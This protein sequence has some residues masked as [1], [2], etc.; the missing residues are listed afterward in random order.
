MARTP[1]RNVVAVE[2]A[3][4]EAFPLQ[5][6]VYSDDDH[7]TAYSLSSSSIVLTWK[8]KNKKSDTAVITKTSANI[9]QIEKTDPT[10]GVF[11][12]KLA[13]TDTVDLPVGSYKFDALLS[14]SSTT[15][16]TKKIIAT[17]EIVVYESSS[18]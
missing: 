15:P 6:T 16:A 1:Y 14:D 2:M 12:V 8:L 3:R 18:L 17:G 4:G 11:V 9:T 5:F 10:N 7:S 13:S